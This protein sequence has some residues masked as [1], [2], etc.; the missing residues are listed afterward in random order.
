MPII[1]NRECLKAVAPFMS[2]EGS[3]YYLNGVFFGNEC[4]VATDGH[5]LGIIHPHA[6]TGIAKTQS[7]ED[8]AFIMPKDTVKQILQTKG[9]F[10]RGVPVMVRVDT[11]SVDV[12]QAN[13]DQEIVVA[14]YQF[15]PIDGV[16]PDYLRVVP[17]I[18]SFSGESKPSHFNPQYL[19]TFQSFGKCVLFMQNKDPA[20]PSVFRAINEELFEALGVLMPM[21][22][23]YG[24]TPE[25]PKWLMN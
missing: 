24:K 14:T 9:P 7:V 16:F 4:L 15:E 1:F 12:F 17:P 10:A 20:S 11:E 2:T 19:A 8:G 3:R 23:D 25:Y 21:R 6:A 5:R 13:K 22:G 18:E